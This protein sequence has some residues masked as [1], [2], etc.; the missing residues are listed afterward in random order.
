MGS[1]SYDFS[2]STVV[3]TG[4]SSGIG[5]KIALRFADAGA[6]VIV[7]DVREKPKDE[8][9]S[10]PTHEKIVADGNRGEFVRTD[11]TDRDSLETCL[12]VA[13]ERG[14]VD[15]MVNNAGRYTTG[16]M[17]DTDPGTFRH[18]H[19]VNVDGVF[20]GTQVAAEGMIRDGTD[21]AIVNLAS[22][23]SSF[24]QR[25]QVPYDSTKGAVEMVTRG[26][27][28]ELADSGIRVN[29]VAPGQIVKGT[30]D[31]A[32]AAEALEDEDLVKPV[33]LGRGGR[34]EDV[35]SAV[36]FLASDGASYVTGETL[37]V[38]GGWQIL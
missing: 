36:L 10:T 6:T 28:L 15:V 35:A 38:D 19:E 30:A 23:S 20:F 1:V 17:L 18:L 33:P 3:V 16:S 14:G 37:Y 12:D 32:A 27:A 21:G 25:G 24:A 26:S 7:A 29:A 9:L 13:H 11:V 8:G 2:D 34:P 31:E 22:I 5:R 4:A